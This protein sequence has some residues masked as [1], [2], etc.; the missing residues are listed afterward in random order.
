MTR[1]EVVPL[2]LEFCYTELARGA[3]LVWARQRF[4]QACRALG[5]DV[6]DEGERMV[7]DL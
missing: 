7:I 5:T 6:R 2:K 3:D 4:T 1:I